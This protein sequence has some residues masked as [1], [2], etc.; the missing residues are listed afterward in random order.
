MVRSAQNSDSQHELAEVPAAVGLACGASNRASGIEQVGREESEHNGRLV[1]GRVWARRTLGTMT[2]SKKIMSPEMFWPGQ[3]VV[4]PIAANA[5]HVWAASLDV[6]R[7]R[8]QQ[9]AATLSCDEH[10]RCTRFR[11]VGLSRRWVAARGLLREMLGEYLSVDPKDIR[12]AYDEHGKPSVAEPACGSPVQFNL[13]HSNS[14]AL[15]AF[16]AGVPV[17]VDTEKVVHF[18][19]MANIADQFFSPAERA[20]LDT[21]A[22]SCYWR[23][24][25]CCWTRK[26]AY[27]K[28]CGVGL[29]LPLDSFDVSV[30]PGERPAL[31]WV[32]GEADAPERWSLVHLRP[33]RRYVGSI[34][35]ETPTPQVTCWSWVRCG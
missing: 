9:L 23:A 33:A 35:V 29:L 21:V 15:Y 7:D 17:G 22:P 10:S 32:Q 6:S 13:S 11:N 3:A 1:G 30:V 12:F 27:L 26:E 28:A 24:F 14:L 20:G 34:A 5:I 18:A 16:S 2:T 8:L 4:D 19:N 25:Y 31:L